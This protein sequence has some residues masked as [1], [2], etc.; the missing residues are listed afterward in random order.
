MNRRKFLKRGSLFIPAAFG[1]PHIVK[2]QTF[3]GSAAVRGAA[4]LQAGSSGGG[5]GGGGFTYYSAVFN[6]SSYETRGAELT[7]NADGQA[8]TLSFW[9]KASA[10]GHIFGNSAIRFRVEIVSSRV[11]IWG[12]KSD[13]TEILRLQTG[14]DADWSTWHHLAAC[15]DLNSS[16]TEKVFVDGVDQT[17]DV[18]STEGQTI[19]YASGDFR[20]GTRGD[21][22]GGFT[23]SLCELWFA[24]TY[25]DISNSTNL[26]KFRTVGGHP[27]NLGTTGQTPTGTT[28]IIYMHNQPGGSPNWFT[29][30]GSGGGF[31]ETGT[32]TDGGSDKP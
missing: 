17:F 6:G 13:D 26:Q 27:E 1:F 7:G 24:L 28:P 8:G 9:A 2:S 10:D 12:F 18:T 4:A 20:I 21:T 3:V 25:L 19:D 31:T 23:G 5:G 11:K 22:F 32:I 30:V 16:G 15:W 29:N 14:S